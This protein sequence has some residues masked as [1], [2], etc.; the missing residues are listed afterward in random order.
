M[1]I[2]TFPPRKGEAKD[3]DQDALVSEENF[4][5]LQVSR[6]GR[7]AE[8]HLEKM[9]DLS[10]L[11]ARTELAIVVK[12]VT[13]GIRRA[14]ENSKVTCAKRERIICCCND[15]ECLSHLP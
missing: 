11:T 14:V 5:T 10:V 8:V 1:L 2:R 15:T 6:S 9:T 3:K 13:V 4:Q 7:Q 12:I